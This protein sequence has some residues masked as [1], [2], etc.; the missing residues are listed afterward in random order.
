VKIQA[1]FAAASA[2]LALQSAFAGPADYVYVPAVEYGEREIDVKAG[3]Q[4]SSGRSRENAYLLG[5]GFGATERWFTEAYVVIEKEDSSGRTRAE[6][7]EWENKFQLTETGRYP[8]DVGLIVEVEVPEEIDEGYELRFGPLLQTDAGKVQLNGN[9]L[10]ER[11]Y[12]AQA[13]EPMQM[14]YQWQVKYRQQREFEYGLQGFG[15]LGPWNDWASQQAHKAGPAVFGRVG[16]GGREA[17]RYNAAYLIGTSSGAPDR[18][19]R[20]QAEYE[21]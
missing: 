9:L 11:R 21:F 2:A 4:K 13:S 17:I 8:V 6:A 15:E 10:F 19:F 16:L 18:T 20:L 7:I 12:R 1:A 5:V 14:G 3:T